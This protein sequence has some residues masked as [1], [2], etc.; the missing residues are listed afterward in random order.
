MAVLAALVALGYQV[1]KSKVSADKTAPPVLSGDEGTT[2][3]T[4][5]IA[6]FP[7]GEGIAVEVEAGR[8]WNGTPCT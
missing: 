2:E 5:E 6:A 8:A 4:K 3:V 7:D 1:E